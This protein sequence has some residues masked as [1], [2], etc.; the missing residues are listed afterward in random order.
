M[1]YLSL[2]KLYYN[3]M[4]FA[5]LIWCNVLQEK[6]STFYKMNAEITHSYK[7]NCNFAL[8][9]RT[10]K[11]CSCTHNPR[12]SAAAARMASRGRGWERHIEIGV[13]NRNGSTSY[14]YLYVVH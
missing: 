14:F 11:H 3:G 8:I 6:L 7:N 4:I 9:E 5:T 12:R 10:D 1:G 13:S 2:S